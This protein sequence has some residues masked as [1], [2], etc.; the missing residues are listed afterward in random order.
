MIPGPWGMVRHSGRNWTRVRVRVPLWRRGDR[1]VSIATVR[2]AAARQ[3]QRSPW[4]REPLGSGFESGKTVLMTVLPRIQLAVEGTRR[5]VDMRLGKSAIE[6]DV[7]SGGRRLSAR[8]APEDRPVA[9]CRSGY[10]VQFQGL[11]DCFSSTAD[12]GATEEF[13]ILVDL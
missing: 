6:S 1:T 11:R 9:F 5:H 12:K 10:G 4:L 2:Q 8:R 13:E 3:R 7:K